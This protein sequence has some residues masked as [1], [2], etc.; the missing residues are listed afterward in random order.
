MTASIDRDLGA[1]SARLDE[2][3]K[4]LSEMRAD[5]RVIRDTLTEARGGWKTLM[6]VGGMSGTIGAFAAKWVLPLIGIVPK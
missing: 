5:L 6:V 3:E 1:H 2:I 4:E